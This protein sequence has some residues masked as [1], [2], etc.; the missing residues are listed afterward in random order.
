M[1]RNK[2]IATVGE[3][4][5]IALRLARLHQ[6]F[7]QMLE[8]HARG[9]GRHGGVPKA[10]TYHTYDTVDCSESGARG[11]AASPNPGGRN[12][13]LTHNYEPT[14]FKHNLGAPMPLREHRAN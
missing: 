2:V 10:S 9:L 5:L 4:P 6:I 12:D 14:G 13:Y 1:Q 7:L 8:H 3:L 11:G